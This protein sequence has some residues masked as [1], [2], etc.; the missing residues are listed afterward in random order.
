MSVFKKRHVIHTYDSIENLPVSLWNK[1]HEKSDYT[2]LKIN[3]INGKVSKEEFAY[4]KKTW[5]VIFSEFIERFGFS[6]NSINILLKKKQIAFLQ[7]Q[8]IESSDRSMHTFIEIEK[9][10]LLEL[11]RENSGHDFWQSKANMEMA[12]GFQIDPINTTVIQFYS[13]REIL[14]TKK[15]SA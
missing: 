1:I 8:F 5:E 13:Y 7:W 10:E 14:M 12:M 2:F 3:R 4:L 9:K 6:E 11:E 15:Q